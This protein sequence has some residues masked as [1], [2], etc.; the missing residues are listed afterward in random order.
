MEMVGIFVYPLENGKLYLNFCS[1]RHFLLIEGYYCS[2]IFYYF[3]IFLQLLYLLLFIW[4]PV[5]LQV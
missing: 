5:T 2:G 1:H 4:R 3:C